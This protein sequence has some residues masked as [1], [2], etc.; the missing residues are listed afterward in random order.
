MSVEA[1]AQNLMLLIHL[2]LGCDTVSTNDRV[3]I[4]AAGTGTRTDCFF[5]HADATVRSKP[6]Y[7]LRES[8]L[9]LQFAS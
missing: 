4:E 7:Q 3:F 5:S 2:V 8:A 9:S 6:L 1:H